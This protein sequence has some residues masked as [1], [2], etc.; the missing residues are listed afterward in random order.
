MK[1][2]KKTNTIAYSNNQKIFS[3]I[4]NV[5]DVFPVKKI[6]FEDTFV[7]APKDIDKI[8]SQMFG[9]YMELPPEEKRHNHYP[10]KLAFKYKEKNR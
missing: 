2:N 4:Y 3:S 9:N 1:S 5:D 6:K 10:Y 7:Y 8:L